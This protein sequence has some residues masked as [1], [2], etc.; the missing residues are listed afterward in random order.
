MT[1]RDRWA[2]VTGASAGIGKAFAESLAARGAHVV[3]VARREDRLAALAATLERDFKTKCEVLAADLADAQAP[4]RV[5]SALAARGIRVDILVNNAGFGM[6]GEFH[7]SPWADHRA[8]VELMVSSYVHFARLAVEGMRARSYGR[9]VN[10][11][12]L[13][14]L[15]PGGAGHTLYGA[16]KAF[17][18]SFSESLAAENRER[19]VKVQALCPG[20]TQSEFHDVNGTRAL[21]S[22]LPKYM[23]MSAEAVAQSSLAGLE[24]GHVVLVPGRWNKS[25]AFL[26]SALPRPAAAALV[27]SQTRKFRRAAGPA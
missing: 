19:G 23:F 26:M 5:M 4:A 22:G 12:S 6:P 9:I 1:Y 14:G 10:V 11:A 21:V 2:L 27:G 16:A 8:F 15:V 17:L 3:L 18:V 13:A 24:R 7:E 20:F 25:V